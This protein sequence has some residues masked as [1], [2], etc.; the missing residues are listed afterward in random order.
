MPILGRCVVQMLLGELD[1]VKES[2]W[3][4]DRDDAGGALPEYLP[5]RDLKEIQGY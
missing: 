3:A 4:W 5:S 2:R 1:S